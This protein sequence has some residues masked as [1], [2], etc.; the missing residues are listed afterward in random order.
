MKSLRLPLALFELAALTLIGTLYLG[1]FL[2]AKPALDT[3]SM[4]LNALHP[5]NRIVGIEHE[6]L[7]GIL[8]PVEIGLTQ[9]QHVPT[10]NPYLSSG[11]PLINDAFNYLFNP[12]HSL[13]VLLL[14]AIQGTKVA[15]MIALLLAG[16]NAW[17]LAKAIGLGAVARVTMGALYMMSGG[18]I[19]KFHTG[20]FQLGLSLV[21]SPLVLA[22]L[23]WTLRTCDRRA[24]VLMAVAFAL[25][26][27]A[28]NIYYTLHTL[29]AAAFITLIY[30]IEQHET[31][32]RWRWDRLRRVIVG[33]AFAL[34]LSALQFM[35][36][37]VV[38]DFVT[39]EDVSFDLEGR[40]V[41]HYDMPQAIINYTYPWA[42]WSIFEQPNFDQLVVVDYAYVGLTVFLFI[43]LLV[44]VLPLTRQRIPIRATFAALLLALLMT[45]WGAGQTPILELLYKR[46]GLLAEFRFI[47]RALSM[48]ALWWIVLAAIG[49]DVLWKAAR[50]FTGVRL[51]FDRYDQVRLL[52]VLSLVALVWMYLFIFS[53]AGNSDRFS[54]ALSSPSLY[55]FL[56]DR[57]FTTLQQA[58][59]VLWWF[60]L[61][62]VIV[63]TIL[64]IA[65]QLPIIGMSRTILSM[66]NTRIMRL[67]L[68]VLAMTAMADVMH[69]NSGLY[70][71]GRAINN[72][73]SL[74][75]LVR[76]GEPENP[77]PAVR[78]PY[79]P[80]AY[81]AYYAEMRNYGLNEGWSPVALPSILPQ[82]APEP[83]ILPGWAIVSNEYGGAS[84]QLSQN[85][86]TDKN[87][88]LIYC[89][90][91]FT[92][93]EPDIDPCDLTDHP[94][95]LL[96]RLTDALPYAF[97]VPEE[98]LLTAAD[99][100]TNNTLYPAS[101]LR[102]E[103]DTITIRA[104]MPDTEN[105]AYLIVQE[106]QF[107]GWQAFVD[108]LPVEPFAFESTSAIK[109]LPGEHIYTL[110]FHPPG[111]STGVTLFVT[112]LVMMVLYL[113]NTK[114]AVQ[115]WTTL[116]AGEQSNG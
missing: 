2:A 16:Y 1:Y 91:P 22:G 110:R 25:M 48:G 73:E 52:R 76:E 69:F 13:P 68:L 12:F 62:A 35:P 43:A 21:W 23:W 98:Q 84:H 38:R 89:Y 102:H 101:V 77:I 45:I 36:I 85:Y 66:V 53:A 78:E 32:F 11:T 61:I 96:Y 29:I 112:T 28:G 44:L 63:D 65:H 111:F 115:N 18:I 6:R 51:A 10:W 83:T 54:L 70:E 104:Q 14:G 42:K 95:S 24:P 67:A 7:S 103:Q 17:A 81:D 58:A 105:S 56:L 114:R 40:I 49:I 116:V 3:Q 39:H 93:S 64:L 33:G 74:Y 59:E 97:V 4:E 20:H 86:V 47:G 34:G 50:E 99:T 87:S 30:L 80:S 88:E 31:G 8:V 15:I 90:T 55:T 107:P 75:P 100:I 37:W 46:I 82:E 57:A 106:V 109:M 19:A 41:G 71:Y 92:I 108:G 9:Y 94:G 5:E 79:S 113:R 60:V 26:F 72:F 27:F